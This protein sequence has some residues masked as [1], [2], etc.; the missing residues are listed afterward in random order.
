MSTAQLK[1][2]RLVEAGGVVVR[3]A[4]MPDASALVEMWEA[5]LGA[6][7]V[8]Q[9]GCEPYPD[10]SLFSVEDMK[11]NIDDPARQI[12]LAE[13]GKQI[14]GAIIVD[15]MSPYHCENNCMAVRRDAYGRGIGSLLIEGVTALLSER[16]FVI[17]CTELVTHSLASQSAHIRRGYD[18]ICGFGYA[19]YPHVFSP[20]H[21]ESVLWSWRLFQKAGGTAVSTANA[22]SPKMGETAGAASMDKSASSQGDVPCFDRTIFVAP[23]YQ[24][25]VKSIV[26]QVGTTLNYSLSSGSSNGASE[27]K[28][29][30]KE[31]QK[32]FYIDVLKCGEEK[33]FSGDLQSA[34]EQ[35]KSTGKSFVLVRINAN[36]PGCPKVVE[37]LRSRQFCFHSFLP[38]YR[39]S[40]D[41]DGFNDLLCMQW[42]A[43]EEIVGNPLPGASGSLI[44]LYGYPLGVTGKVID[45]IRR[46]V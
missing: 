29:D 31:G 12:V 7:G 6:G 11:S 24:E 22:P 17:N 33:D 27:L 26:E 3:E 44:Q 18:T 36:D 46:E 43:P 16:E 20:V 40:P 4:V 23:R 32:H 41:G 45:T 34:V 38:L 10:P 5:A 19:H 14:L 8:W 28:I 42:I 13:D 25:L 35:A 15:W 39:Y 9:P 30:P 2:S 1:H 21:R 37:W